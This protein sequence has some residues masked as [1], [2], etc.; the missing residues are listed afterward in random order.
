MLDLIRPLTQRDEIVLDL[1]E[2]NGL[3]KRTDDVIEII[4]SHSSPLSKSHPEN[5]S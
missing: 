3:A 5:R 2:D 4:A 1:R